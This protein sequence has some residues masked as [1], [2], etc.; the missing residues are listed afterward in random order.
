MNEKFRIAMNKQMTLFFTFVVLLSTQDL[1]SQIQYGPTEYEKMRRNQEMEFRLNQ[2]NKDDK[3]DAP[4][5]WV[6]AFRVDESSLLIVKTVSRVCYVGEVSERR[7]KFL[8]QGKGICKEDGQYCLCQWKRDF[9]HGKG[10]MRQEDGA[11][12]ACEW[13]WDAIVKDSIRPA[14]EEETAQFNEA[15]ERLEKLMKL[16]RIKNVD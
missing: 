9:R 10:I 16:V 3:N 11:V 4:D 14:S 7:G 1:F 15:V 2:M 5:E 13:R 6:L 12:V 8:R